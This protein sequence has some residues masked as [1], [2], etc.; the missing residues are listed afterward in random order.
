MRLRL[1]IERHALPTAQVLWTTEAFRPG[2]N[3]TRD[4]LTIAQLLENVNEVI[5]LETIDWGLEDY[6]V[7]VR[8]FE[9]LHF[10]LTSQ[11]LKDEDEVTIR[12][13]Q[14]LDIRYRR[15]SGR[16]QISADGKHLIDGVPFGRPFLRLHKRP[17]IMIPPRKRQKLLDNDDDSE[18]Q[19]DFTTRIAVNDKQ[20]VVREALQDEDSG[21]ED[22][23]DF[24]LQVE[25]EEQD[26]DEDDSSKVFQGVYSDELEDLVQDSGV[27][28]SPRSKRR[29]GTPPP[30]MMEQDLSKTS[31]K[32]RKPTSQ[33]H[34]LGL[35]HAQS[36]RVENAHI[37]GLPS[38]DSG[39]A[40]TS[41][42]KDAEP[43]TKRRKK[44]RAVSLPDFASS[45]SRLTPQKQPSSARI[46]R[47]DSSTKGKSVRFESG[48]LQ[49]PVTEIEGS[50]D[51]EAETLLRR[52]TNNSPSDS[53][54]KENVEPDEN[55]SL[56]SSDESI[57]ETSS[58]STDEDT[59][60]DNSISDD[61]TS[62][63]DSSEEEQADGYQ[64]EKHVVQETTVLGRDVK[65]L[66]QHE[67]GSKSGQPQS[68]PGK[69]QQKTKARNQRRKL[70]KKM[71]L[72][73]RKGILQADATRDDF[74]RWQTTSIG[75][76]RQVDRESTVSTSHLEPEVS[77]NLEARKHTILRSLNA[78][79]EPSIST[80]VFCTE[81]QPNALEGQSKSQSPPLIE[82]TQDQSASV[83]RNE[84][85]MNKEPEEQSSSVF[86][87]TA[88][89]QQ[90][91]TAPIPSTRKTKLDMAS[92][93]RLLF[94]SLGLRAPR[95][96]EEE[97]RL[98]DK[99]NVRTPKQ[100]AQSS[101]AIETPAVLPPAGDQ[102]DDWQEKIVLSAVECCYEGVEL[103]TPHFP[104]VQ[105]WDPQQQAR[106]RSTRSRKR[107]RNSDSE[108]PSYKEHNATEQEDDSHNAFGEDDSQGATLSEVPQTSDQAFPDN[109]NDAANE[110][111]MR[112]AD[113]ISAHASIAQST[114]SEDLP[115]LPV[116]LHNCINLTSENVAI[117]AVIAFRQLEVSAE[118]KWQ[119]ELSSYQT[120]VIQDI[121]GKNTFSITLAQRDRPQRERHY[122]PSSGRRL[123]DKFDAPESEDEEEDDDGHREV[124]LGELVD[125][126]LIRA[127]DDGPD[128]QV[129]HDRLQIQEG[130]KAIPHVDTTSTPSHLGDEPNL[131]GVSQQTATNLDSDTV[132]GLPEDARMS[133][134]LEQKE[135]DE[136]L[137]HLEAS[138]ISDKTRA[139]I[140]I[141]IRGAGFRS[142]VNS[143]VN[144]DLP[145]LK[146]VDHDQDI[147][148][149]TSSQKAIDEAPDSPYIN[150][151]GTNPP[152]GVCADTRGSNVDTQLGND[153]HLS[154]DIPLPLRSVTVRQQSMEGDASEL[155]PETI[156]Q[157]T[158][159]TDHHSDPEIHPSSSQGDQSYGSDLDENRADLNSIASPLASTNTSP[160]V[161]DDADNTEM[162][163]SDDATQSMV[164]STEEPENSANVKDE[165]QMYSDN[166]LP[167]LDEIFSIAR[168]QSLRTSKSAKIDANPRTIGNDDLDGM[169]DP[170]KV[171]RSQPNARARK[172]SS[173]GGPK[174]KPSFKL[175]TRTSTKEADSAREGER[176]P[177]SQ[178]HETRTSYMSQPTFVDLTQTSDPI[179][180]T[181]ST[182][183]SK[184]A[185]DNESS[186]KSNSA[187][188]RKAK[189]RKAKVPF[190]SRTKSR[191]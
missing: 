116:D 32:P 105:R 184:D 124:T 154:E 83:S 98:R 106:S 36:V 159:E 139:D 186:F 14:T 73:K 97:D 143:E 147:E 52:T 26:T 43:A 89:S 16:E 168:S 28:P 132:A 104:F 25:D 5:P 118:T 10:S 175:H 145:S 59:S 54:D 107:K 112:D 137:L 190:K 176:Q 27:S 114:Q 66:K 87:T 24:Q 40:G 64:V 110:Q 167:S 183:P 22:D 65:S 91:S 144:Q 120:A 76:N 78:N 138:Q 113:G 50:S 94:G 187:K 9:C 39:S 170:A 72:L 69:G 85:L 134:S 80:K 181:I 1:F 48:V 130:L 109:Y 11:V 142:T 37:L 63:S 174:D 88:E 158:S 42:T 57:S 31:P 96:K 123:Y 155:L 182:E 71:I 95:T 45:P 12:P 23:T 86:L 44:N 56:S 82:N 6:V 171:T 119:P 93:R 51:S 7:E 47:R 108:V 3:A 189:G 163:S 92:T 161:G 115:E 162:P 99:L 103:S 58:D 35:Q 178:A 13:L 79:D 169:N 74:V 125:A 15:L 81:D 77:D 29:R 151:F 53:S 20:I 2:S 164:P 121:F 191:V 117:G 177:D 101:R 133:H 185:S 33:L 38:A 179:I 146:S 173:K 4:K 129:D 8:G 157:T 165:Q 141:L 126:K 61:T 67:L 180:Q 41:S 62:A 55:A 34:G 17:Q 100:S 160:V 68:A 149:Y 84:D 166:S 46:R 150:D 152:Q 153:S 102:Q 148:E 90:R 128:R 188:M 75:H 127:G 49:T 131:H 140:S 30:G 122:D 21:E 111:L 135:G 60:S 136:P 70:A 156:P 19:D 172:Q 18:G